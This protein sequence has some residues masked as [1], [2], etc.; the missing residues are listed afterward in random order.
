MTEVGERVGLAI[1]E[2]M[3]FVA[4]TPLSDLLTR[5]KPKRCWRVVGFFG[6]TP[7]AQKAILGLGSPF[8]IDQVWGL[9]LNPTWRYCA[10]CLLLGRALPKAPECAVLRHAEYHRVPWPNVVHVMHSL[11]IVNQMPAPPQEKPE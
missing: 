7:N 2:A 3:G 11:W 6:T 5:D 10:K 8:A 9:Q 1:S 4:A